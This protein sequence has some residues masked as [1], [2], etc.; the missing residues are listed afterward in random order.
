MKDGEEN[1]CLRMVTEVRDVSGR[2]G[3]G[4]RVRRG[5]GRREDERG[6]EKSVE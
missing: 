4:K 6:T 5:E 3:K 1:E 2:E